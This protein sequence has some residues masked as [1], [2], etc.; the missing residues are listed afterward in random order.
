MAT[1]NGTSVGG[2]T[3]QIDYSYTQNTT[4]NTTS[5]TAKLQLVSHY[6]LYATALGGSYISV[7]GSRTDYSKSIS[8]GGSSTTTT[9]LAT[10]TVTV[11]HNNDGTGSCNLS[12][13]FVMNGTYRNIYVGTMTVSSTIALPTIP[14]SSGLT[15]PTSVNTGTTL[16]GSVAPSNSAFNHKLEFKIG[17]T[18]KSTLTLAANQAAPTF[19]QAIGHD[20]FP[21]STS[22][23]ITVVLSTYSGTTLIAS[24]SKNV[25]ANVPST[26]V[27]SVSA[28]TAA[29][30]ASGLSGLYVQGKTTAK[31]TATATAGSG[32]SIK[33]YEYSGP[34]VYASTTSNNTTTEA[35]Q[36]SGTLTY[37]VRVTDLRGRT[38]SKTVQIYVYPYSAPS[39][40]PVD[41][42]RCDANGN[43]TE[44][45]T[46]AKY[47]V[48]ST[49]ASVNSKNTRTVTVAYSS[50]NG[51][52]YSAETTIQAATDTA[53]TKTG[54]YGSST[55]ALASTYILRFTIK[56]AYG[57]TDTFTAPLQSAARPINIRSNGKGVSIGGMSTKDGFECSFDADFNKNV[58]IDG[59]LTTV[60]KINNV[61]VNQDT[62]VLGG[63]KENIT[64]ENWL[65]TAPS[66]IGTYSQND[67]WYST[68]SCR[69]RNGQGDGTSYGLQ[70][71]SILTKADNLSW[72][73]NMNGSWGDWKTILDSN[74]TADYVVEQGVSSDWNYTKWNS[75]KSEAW[76]TIELGD[77][78][79]TSSLAGGV[80]SN[81]S[82]NGRGV[83]LPTGLFTAIP[84]AFAN[85]YSNGYTICQVASANTTQL[86]Y[87]LW[88]PYSATVSGVIVSLYVVGRW[89]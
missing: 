5:V 30:A 35:I 16:S 70:L 36:T 28:F 71:R 13:T 8:Y 37:T 48:N 18:V 60:G 38:A 44:S 79:L 15:V 10:K 29:I 63:S 89:K 84:L 25:T 23:V 74:N 2:M 65:S 4:A 82:Y 61:D 85:V 39:I 47:T 27:P 56:D 3:L 46:Y 11:S 26:V 7:G 88:S 51:T 1:I 20:W 58:N 53:S 45:G 40:G 52:S 33:S 80:Y 78:P 34:N 86:V 76:R 68:I 59:N 75:G 42:K 55:F 50:N 9:V 21:N 67:Q 64:N 49:Y 19:T 73:Q 17:S 83:T 12:G 31:L 81:T 62:Y 72:R 14:R 32:S 66:F 41:V 87:R 43:L 69:H 54:V 77:V 22:G 24:T 57:V 6:A